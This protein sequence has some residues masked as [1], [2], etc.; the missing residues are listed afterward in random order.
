MKDIKHLLIVGSQK[1]GTTYLSSL[2]LQHP[3]IKLLQEIKEPDFFTRHWYKGKEWYYRNV[4]DDKSMFYLDAS[5]SYTAAPLDPNEINSDKKHLQPLKDVPQRIAETTNNIRFIYI[6]RDPVKRAYSSYWHNVRA[7]HENNEFREALTASSYYLR[8][9]EY[10]EQIQLYLQ[11]FKCEQFLFLSFE[12]FINN[13]VTVTKK[14]F[15]F[16]ELDDFNLTLTN[17]SKNRSFIYPK[18][19]QALNRLTSK[20]GGLNKM[21]KTIQP[22]FPEYLIQFF[23]NKIT[24]QTPTIKDEDKDFLINYYR[25]KNLLLDEFLEFDTRHWLS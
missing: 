1:S 6:M 20:H 21:I 10:Y 24:H 16:L 3:K 4:E 23:G 13:P 25:E 14:C 22:A 8:L 12:D 15:Q 19:L 11:Y 5:T 17:Q 7:G 18:Y 2:L 9:G